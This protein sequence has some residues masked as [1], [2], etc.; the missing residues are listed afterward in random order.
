MS[1]F[2]IVFTY[3]HGEMIQEEASRYMAMARLLLEYPRWRWG[4]KL[5]EALK[6]LVDISSFCDF[7]LYEQMEKLLPGAGEKFLGSPPNFQEVEAGSSEAIHDLNADQILADH[8]ALS[9][10]ELWPNV[11]DAIPSD[12]LFGF[13]QDQTLFGLLEPTEFPV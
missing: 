2:V 5:N 4:E 9:A 1:A 13:V 6:T 10:S 7:K 11:F 3:W 8:E 12:D